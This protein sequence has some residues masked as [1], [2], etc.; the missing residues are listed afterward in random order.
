MPWWGHIHIERSERIKWGAKKI[1]FSKTYCKT[2]SYLTWWAEVIW[3]MTV[4]F[5]NYPWWHDETSQHSQVQGMVWN[6]SYARFVPLDITYHLDLTPFTQDEQRPSVGVLLMVVKY[7]FYTVNSCI[8]LMEN[9]HQHWNSG[10]VLTIF[11]SIGISSFC[12]RTHRNTC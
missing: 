1:L 3:F 9:G 5:L 4:P 11:T 10:F 6:I 2:P 7:H 8:K 12:C